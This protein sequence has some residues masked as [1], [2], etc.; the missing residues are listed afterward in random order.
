M[1]MSTTLLMCQSFIDL[2][3]MCI[4]QME[5]STKDKLLMIT[6]IATLMVQVTSMESKSHTMTLTSPMKSITMEI[7]ALLMTAHI[8]LM[9]HLSLLISLE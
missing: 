5:M 4:H 1:L 8:A 7:R 2:F 9:K 3:T 6:R